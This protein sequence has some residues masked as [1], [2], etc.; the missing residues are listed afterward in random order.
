MGQRKRPYRALSEG[1]SG[2]AA[3][4]EAPFK[5][6]D[7]AA[8]T[9]RSPDGSILK[10]MHPKQ[11]LRQSPAGDSLMLVSGKDSFKMEVE[12]EAYLVI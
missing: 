11:A 9:C 8:T 4:G 5:T 10:A 12:E 3:G 6:G 2:F 1:P 7:R